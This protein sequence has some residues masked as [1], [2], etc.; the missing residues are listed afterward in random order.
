MDFK[1]LIA[2]SAIADLRNIVEFVAEDDP[3]AATRLANKLIDRALSL[4]AL[5]HRCPF[6]DERRGIRKMT[7]RPYL[8][9]Y[10]CDDESR[11]VNIIHFWH[12]ARLAPSF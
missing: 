11:I 7:I 4:G 9:F 8:V 6:F 10:T 2:E 12:G 1:I 5:P 3:H